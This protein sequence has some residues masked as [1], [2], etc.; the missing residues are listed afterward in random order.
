MRFLAIATALVCLVPLTLAL[1]SAEPRLTLAA[2]RAK[3]EIYERHIIEELAVLLSFDVLVSSLGLADG[4]SYWRGA[5]QS[6]DPTFTDRLTSTV[7][8]FLCKDGGDVAGLTE[9]LVD[10]CGAR[11]CIGIDVAIAKLFSE[12]L[13]Y[14]ALARRRDN[15]AM[16]ALLTNAAIEASIIA[17][18]RDKAKKFVST[19]NQT[20]G[21]NAEREQHFLGLVERFFSQVLIPLTKDLEIKV[22]HRLALTL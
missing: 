18:V 8:Q 20:S 22:L 17:R 2:C 4:A 9:T 16:L 1:S 21:D 12:P 14:C 11:A 19:T 7:K 13:T 10:I 5:V 15:T 6:Y 3:L